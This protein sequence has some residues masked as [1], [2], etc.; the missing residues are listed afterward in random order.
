MAPGV[1]RDGIYKG[2]KVKFNP[3]KPLNGTANF[4]GTYHFFE[5]ESL[6]CFFEKAGFVVEEAFFYGKK[7]KLSNNDQSEAEKLNNMLAVGIVARKP[8]STEEKK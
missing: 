7:G 3:L 8:V 1:L 4:H 5:P 2:K 6:S